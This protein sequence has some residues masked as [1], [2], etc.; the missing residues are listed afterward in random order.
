MNINS[1]TV[2]KNTLQIDKNEDF[3]LQFKWMDNGELQEDLSDFDFVI[4]FFYKGDSDQ[5][6]VEY[7]AIVDDLNHIIDFTVPVSVIQRD[8]NQHHMM[9]AICMLSDTSTHV[10][11]QGDVLYHG[12]SINMWRPVYEGEP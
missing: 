11:V 2:Y 1:G 4:K 6:F 12:Y 8:F 3:K 10:L 5:P 9:Y 7:T